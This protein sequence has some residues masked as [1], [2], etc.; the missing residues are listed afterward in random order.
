VQ[1][2]PSL[3][4]AEIRSLQWHPSKSW[5]VQTDK[6]GWL[7]IRSL[8]QDQQP[9]EIKIDPNGNTV[10]I[11]RWLPDGRSIAVGLFGG[12]VKE[13]RAGEEPVAFD[14]RHPDAVQGLAVDPSTGRLYSSDSFG[15]LWVWDIKTRKKLFELPPVGEAQDVIDLSAGGR[16]ALTA[17]NGGKV[18]LY[19]VEAKRI[20]KQLDIDAQSEGAGFSPDGKL[21]AAVDT[22]GRLHVWTYAGDGESEEFAT[23][24]VYPDELLGQSA[25]PTYLRRLTWLPEISAIAIASTRGEVKLVSY[26]VLAWVQRARSVF[27]SK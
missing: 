13:W 18:T 14:A 17:G 11:A 5:L 25:Q 21:I 19:D 9:D 6:A 27:L 4:G 3:R 24:K 16:I 26:D 2:L 10:D 23:V 22:E 12:E 1:S 20:L 8:N 7:A 15:N